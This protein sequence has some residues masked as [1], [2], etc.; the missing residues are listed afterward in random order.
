M[1]R[2]YAVG[3]GNCEPIRSFQRI[4]VTRIEALTGTGTDADP[5]RIVQTWITDEGSVLVH[6][7][8]QASN[9]EPDPA[10]EPKP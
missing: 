7:D 6:F 9:Q 5:Y 10:S 2:L 8:P 4:E 1:T 3:G